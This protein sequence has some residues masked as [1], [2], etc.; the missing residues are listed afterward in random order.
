MS[1]END[2]L[3]ELYVS[4]NATGR[5]AYFNSNQSE[6]VTRC[7]YCGDSTS[8]ANHGHLYISTIAPFSFFCQRCETKG[9][10]NSNTIKE[11]E[12]DNPALTMEI[13][14]IATAAIKN[15][16]KTF[17]NSGLLTGTR[18]LI[19]P[20]YKIDTKA[21]KRKLDYLEKRFNSELSV[22]D[23]KALKIIMNYDDFI[24]KN[25]LTNMD[26][27]YATSEYNTNLR[28]WLRMYSI[29]FLSTDTNYINF[30]HVKLPG[31]DRRYYTESNNRPIDVGSRIFTIE[32]EI[33]LFSPNIKLI[34]AEGVMDIA[35]IWI[36][37]YDK[38]QDKDVVF[39]AVN[40]RAYK[41][42]INTMRRMGF[43]TIDLE[44][45]S[46]A[47]ITLKNYMYNLNFDHFSKIQIH[48]N[49]FEGEKDFGVP[50]ERIKKKTFKL[51]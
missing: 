6:L 10:L 47:E 35:S 31:N 44:I 8:N 25:R 43:F 48:Y 9:Y 37:L 39:G 34:L 45:Y 7:P 2:A 32:N 11:F 33:D 29:G 17:S 28:K 38:L 15:T 40:G 36:N 27:Y 23:L 13:S 1:I 50:K 30:R 51:K 19:L 21:F 18:K 3:Q 22:D 14:K 42:F 16:T 12:I 5:L 24:S 49:V 41:L 4:I 46:D 20:N 26:K